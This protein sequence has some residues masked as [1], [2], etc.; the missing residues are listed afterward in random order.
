M[1]KAN[2]P[3]ISLKNWGIC[4]WDQNEAQK[5]RDNYGEKILPV[6]WAF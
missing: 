5:S 6:P 2:R 1:S 3:A 4:S